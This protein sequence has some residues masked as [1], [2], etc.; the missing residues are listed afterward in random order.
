VDVVRWF[1]DRSRWWG[2]DG[3]LHRLLEHAAY[4]GA[5]LGVALVAGWLL[6]VLAGRARRPSR[7]SRRLPV[8]VRFLG[9]VGLGGV[10]AA[11][12]PFRPWLVVVLLGVLA[13][14]PVA[15]AVADGFASVDTDA[16][17]AAEALGLSGRQRFFGVEV[18]CA[19]PAMVAGVRAA[20]VRLVVMVAV[21]AYPDLGGLGRFIVDEGRVGAMAGMVMVGVLALAADVLGALV[22]R[23]VT[24]AGL[25][26]S[27]PGRH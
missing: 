25:R 12:H 13:T 19:L 26:L 6:G 24:P 11:L 4:V 2:P 9:L 1:N 16:L 21:A 5:A 27:L 23:W 20:V 22:Q 8:V 18:R 17:D 15:G 3:I 14:G 7:R 10:V